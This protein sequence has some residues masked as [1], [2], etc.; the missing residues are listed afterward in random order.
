MFRDVKSKIGRWLDESKSS[1]FESFISNIV[2][3]E[4]EHP[5]N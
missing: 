5:D 2:I 3:L 4:S 1:I